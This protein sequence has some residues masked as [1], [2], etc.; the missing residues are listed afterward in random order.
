MRVTPLG[1]ASKQLRA[2][3]GI[4]VRDL[5]SRIG[6]SPAY[7]A[8]IEV[9]GEYRRRDSTHLAGVL[10]ELPAELH[11]LARRSEL[12]DAAREM[13]VGHLTALARSARTELR[14]HLTFELVSASRNYFTVA[15]V[16]AGSYRS[17]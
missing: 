13:D 4:T 3:H 5:A 1:R 17:I 14:L 11:E 2:K 15:H 7:V 12:S 8:K 6:K 10:G 9:G 16:P